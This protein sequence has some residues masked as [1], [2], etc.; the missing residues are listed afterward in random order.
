MKLSAV[1]ITYNE[2]E[3]IEECLRSVMPVAEEIIVVD[4]YSTDNT[5]QICERYGATVIKRKF[6]GFSNQKNF[7]NAYARMEYILS[8]DADE[9]LSPE[10]HSSIKK[11]LINPACDAYEVNRLNNYCGRW[12]KHGTWY[13]DKKIR[14]W[15]NGT[16][17]WEGALHEKLVISGTLCSLSGDLLHLGIKNREE[18]FKTIDRYSTIAAED[19]FQ[20]GKKVNVFHLL[21]KP[22]F[23]FL[24]SYFFRFG[25][26]D[27]TAGLQIAKLSTYDMYLRYKKLHSL[28]QKTGRS[29]K[30]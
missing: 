25:F 26:L 21:G 11:V 22:A 2:E 24:R 14:L 15:K 8:I 18:H 6:D 4:S 29:E 28:Y 1:I 13:P 10:L 3:V 9:R 17:K 27:G 30:T 16:A 23:V 20:R 19:L 5:V 7:A 12:I